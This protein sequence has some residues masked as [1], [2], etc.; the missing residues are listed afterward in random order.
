MHK[1]I[2]ARPSRT[3]FPILFLL[4]TL[5]LVVLM[6]GCG[7]KGQEGISGTSRAQPAA[8]LEYPS[9]LSAQSSPEEVGRTLIEALEAGQKKTLLGLVAV[10]QGSADIEGIYR[11]HGR[12]SDMKPEAVAALAVAGWSATCSF[13]QFGQTQIERH[14]IQGDSAIVYA[15]G[16]TRDG[17]RRTLEIS[18]VREDGFWKV[19]PGIQV[20]S[21]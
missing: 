8:I 20:L 18:L 6:E 1:I 11:K 15:A 17:T 3:I 10:K 19:C 14:E 4:T 21:K 2:R 13:F 5:C 16:A 7:R 12:E 9:A